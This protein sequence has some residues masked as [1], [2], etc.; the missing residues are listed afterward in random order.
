M[1]NKWRAWQ[2]PVQEESWSVLEELEM[3]GLAGGSCGAQL[4]G[5]WGR[6]TGAGGHSWHGKCPQTQQ[7]AVPGKSL[8]LHLWGCHGLRARTSLTPRGGSTQKPLLCFGLSAP[9]SRSPALLPLQ[10][11]GCSC[12]PGGELTSASSGGEQGALS[13][14]AQ[15]MGTA[16]DRGRSSPRAGQIWSR[17]H[18][19]RSSQI[20][21]PQVP[22]Q[23]WKGGSWEDQPRAD[24][25]EGI[26]A[27]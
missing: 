9:V 27:A 13:S 3:E 14:S 17:F 18:T 11:P 24:T 16:W 7:R 12:S 22:T 10:G 21:S 6:G 1:L 19:D 2:K 25:A 20:L 5:C 23:Q 8:L 26:W 4:E 15:D